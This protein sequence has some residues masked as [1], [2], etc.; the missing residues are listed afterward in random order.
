MPARPELTRGLQNGVWEVCENTLYQPAIGNSKEN[1]FFAALAIA[2]HP[3]QTLEKGDELLRAART[4][5][6]LLEL[7][8]GMKVKVS[9]SDNQLRP[10]ICVIRGFKMMTRQDG[11][12]V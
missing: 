8:P 4:S 3:K 5:G 12:H 6:R 1:K 2:W 9:N 10:E 11:A 7:R